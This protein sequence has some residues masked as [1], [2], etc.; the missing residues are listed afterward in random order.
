[1]DRDLYADITPDA[2]RGG[3]VLASR[4]GSF[5]ASGEAHPFELEYAHASVTRE[6]APIEHSAADVLEYTVGLLE[7]TRLT[8][9][10]ASAQTNLVLGFLT[11][12]ADLAWVFQRR[13]GHLFERRVRFVS[14][15]RTTGARQSLHETLSEAVADGVTSIVVIDEVV[16]G[17][18]MRT[19]IFAVDEWATRSGCADTL[20]VTLV[21]MRPEDGPES[22]D[23]M[24]RKIVA[25]SRKRRLAL[26]HVRVEFVQVPKL[27]AKDTEGRPLK[28]VWG[29]AGV[30]YGANRVWPG[31]YRVRCPNRLTCEGCS[32]L[33]V[34][35]SAASLDQVFA[36]VVFQIAGFQ[37]CHSGVWPGDIESR[38]CRRCRALLLRARQIASDLPRVAP[39]W[40][41]QEAR[42]VGRISPRG[43]LDS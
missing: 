13:Y 35:W 8:C 1:M 4:P 43:N 17:A 20:H 21:G 32:S 38:G 9:M 7:V 41:E 40:H 10:F 19:N 29:G 27:L 24:S 14:G 28:S 26:R 22:D 33:N 23:E 3:S 30:R 16:S 5:L 15:L 11:G 6:D 37:P 36:N 39:P 31:G 42:V 34:I 2:Q 18:Q 25:P 12:S